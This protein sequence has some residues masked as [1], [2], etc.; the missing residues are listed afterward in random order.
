MI[1][2]KNVSKYLIV[3]D[4]SIRNGLR[5]IEA[6][7]DGVIFC[8][9]NDGILQGVLTDGDVRRW[10]MTAEKVSVDDA[11]ATVM[12]RD[13]VHA[14]VEDNEDKIKANLSDRVSF[15]PLVDNHGRCVA[16]V[17]RRKEQFFIGPRKVGQGH[18]TFIIAEIGN[19]HNGDVDMAK[20][21]V[22]EAIAAGADCAKFQMRDLSS[23][24]KNAGNADDASEDLG[25]QYTLDL[26]SRFQLSNDQM[27]EVFD[28]C[29]AR[30]IM[31]MCTPWDENSLAALESYGM[32]A[33]KVASADLT[34]HDLLTA[35]ARTGKPMVCSTGMST[36]PEIA[37][38]IRLL[39]RLGA[40]FALL[41]CNSTYPAPFRDLNLGFM[42]KLRGM[43]ECPTGYSSHDRGI[44]I[45]AAAVA[46][47]ANII[48]KHFTLD[49]N[50]EGN[51]HRVSLLPQEFADMVTAV[52]Q[53]EMA[54]EGD[55]APRR[56]SQGEIMNR[57]ALGKSLVINC[58]LPAGAL[59][60]DH[61]VDVRSPGRGLAPYRKRDVI[62][63]M[64]R[65]PL[66]K[67]DILFEA[68]IAD[69][70]VKPRTYGFNRPF[71]IPVRYHDLA[72]LMPL[73]NYDLFEFHLSYKDMEEDLSQ[74]F[75]K[76]LDYGL[77]VHAPELF[78]RDH[79]LDLCSLD[80][81]YRRHSMNELARVIEITRRLQSYFTRAER[82]CIIIN[83]GGF[84]QDEPLPVAQRRQRY[85][86]ILDSLA[87]LD[88]TGVEII[89]QT[90]PPFPWHFGGQRYQNLFMDADEIVEVCSASGLRV[91]LDTSHSK[92]ACTHHKWSF[93]EF[94][95]KVG[96]YTAHLHL[97]DSRG[98]DGEGLQIGEGEIALG[99]MG[100][101]LRQF[102][103]KASFIPEIWQGHKNGGE[104][105]W[106][107]LERLERYL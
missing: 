104:G 83:A 103:P 65:R 2:D 38:S 15:L 11:I 26:L 19:N 101:M 54:M 64:S 66:Q 1:I 60:E 52:R 72:A 85:D 22:D 45:V 32:Q 78:A 40:E 75:S 92:L 97:A 98:V 71:G 18:P 7:E 4:E 6:N 68:D 37:E 74:Y 34:N 87:Q 67:G 23:L 29:V 46:L 79:V 44:N 56:L 70:A 102:A 50:L 59:I 62:G 93:A 57:E 25:T 73:S 13:Y 94:V 35:I 84:T 31:P 24:Y 12:N 41:H 16:I 77:V 106:V 42:G 99:E 17:R 91:C 28:Y 107:A 3:A 27:F 105:F 39:R 53:V 63:R 49:R 76:P 9:D 14:S 95:R 33:Y 100:A 10:I 86:M 8:V 55:G 69:V 90:M 36:E 20:R 88:T 21:L 96:P 89:P 5:K 48:E 61:M 43:G 51:D 80:P 81:E 30:G 82:P 47:G 58:D